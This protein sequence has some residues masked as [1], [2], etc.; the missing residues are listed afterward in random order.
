MIPFI[1]WRNVWFIFSGFLILGSLVAVII[2]GLK[3][4][5]DFTGGSLLEVQ[6][7][8]SRP[9]IDQME[10]IISPLSLGAVVLQPSGDKN[11]IIRSKFLT[12]DQHQAILKTLSSPAVIE[13][14]FE[15]IGPSVSAQLR[16]RSIGAVIAVVLGMMFFIA[17]AFRKVSRPVASWKYGATA[18]VAL[19]HDIAITTGLFAFL[20]HFLGVEVNVPFVVALLTVMGYSVHDTIV[21]FDRIR[22]NLI[23]RGSENFDETV[24]LAINQTLARSVNT[25]MTVLLVLAAMFLFGGETIHYFTLALIVGILA[26]TYSSIFVASPILVVWEAWRRRKM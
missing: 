25:S 16:Q 3:P 17:Y 8:D 5:I 13:E 4:G 21:V 18:I 23:K 20:G 7:R 19:V 6:F 11:I 9:T 1:R 15:A 12:E 2:F 10:K 26:G 22:E 14:R 24:N